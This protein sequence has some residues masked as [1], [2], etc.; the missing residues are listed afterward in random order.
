MTSDITKCWWLSTLDANKFAIREEVK[1]NLIYDL[2]INEYL[3]RESKKI[4]F[5]RFLTYDSFEKEFLSENISIMY[6]ICFR[7]WTY[8]VE[9][10]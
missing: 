2:A 8:D 4:F 7:F 10:R 5:K 6:R 9:N 3:E 1:T